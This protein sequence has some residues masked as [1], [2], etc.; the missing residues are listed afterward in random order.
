MHRRTCW[1]FKLLCKAADMAKYVLRLSAR[2]TA[3]ACCRASTMWVPHFKND[4]MRTVAHSV[5]AVPGSASPLQ[6]GAPFCLHDNARSR[7]ASQINGCSRPRRNIRQGRTALPSF[8]VDTVGTDR[9]LLPGDK[10]DRTDTQSPCNQSS[11][12]WGGS[13]QHCPS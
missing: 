2:V 3:P 12:R 5:M 7:P 4:R 11:W 9:A 6:Y 10:S 13:C 8:H 1:R